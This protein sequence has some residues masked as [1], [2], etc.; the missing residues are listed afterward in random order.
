MKPVY[1]D[2]NATTPI[3]P[4]VAAAMKPYLEQYF[5]NPSSVHEYGVQTRNAIETAREQVA[6]LIGANPDEIIFT[7]GG[8]ESN[9]FAIKGIAYARQDIGR[10]I[11][12]SAIEHPAVAEVCGFLERHGFEITRLP[13]TPEGLVKVEDVRTAL[14]D[15]TIL[16]TIMHANN[17]TGAIQPIEEIARLARAHTIALHTDAAQSTGKIPVRV[18]E[19]GVDL[20]TIAG[21]KLYAPKGIG[22]LYIRRGVQLEKLMHGANH[23]QNKRP[24]TENVLEIVGL[25]KACEIAGRDLKR[26]MRHMRQMRDMLH[27][28]LQKAGLVF[29]LNGPREKRLPNTLSLAFHKVEA[30]TALSELSGV[31]ASAGAACHSDQIDVSVVLEAMQ[32][33]IDYAMGTIRFS[34][35]RFTTADQIETAA[36]MVTDTIRRLQKSDLTTVD[37]ETEDVIRLTRYTHGMGCACKIQPA[38]LEDILRKLPVLRDENVLVGTD[39]SDDA[40]VYRLNDEQAVVVT[41]DFFTPIADD[42]GDFGAIAAA[43]ALSDLYAMGARPLFALNLVGFPIDRLPVRVL[44]EILTG[45]RKKAEE[46]GIHIIGGHTIEDTEPKFGLVAVGLVHPDQVWRNRGML[47]GD[48]LVLTKPI[49]TGVLSTALKRG[50]LSDSGALI[51]TM[52]ALNKDAAEVMRRFDIHACTD[53]TGFGLLG[54]LSEMTVASKVDVIV[55]ADAVPLLDGVMRYAAGGAIPGGTRANLSWVS[56]HVDWSLELTDLQRLVLCDA[57]TSGGLLASVPE[58]QISQLLQALDVDGVRAR[59]IGKV[60]R[61]G[62]G[63]IAVV[64]EKNVDG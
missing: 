8:T 37:P 62:T 64:P 9:N 38:M 4:E 15:D 54:H 20:L 47:P 21:H 59:V 61:T 14:R 25:G 57:Q 17:E 1:L 32:V 50:L 36:G 34:T 5:G 52:S 2:Y 53:V 58:S 29:R 27:E 6:A 41:T 30:N 51:R 39:T 60:S 45:A 35:G 22:A 40:A 44:E 11:V 55:A 12:T 43:N 42:P 24:G 49:G 63:R 3:A 16:I 31:A 33:P 10:H 19:L 56:R 26:N 7:S 46:A 13:V 28:L 18:D 48:V 23:E